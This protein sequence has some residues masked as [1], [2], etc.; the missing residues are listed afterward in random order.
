M[1]KEREYISDAIE[2][3]EDLEIGTNFLVE[4]LEDFLEVNKKAFV[5]ENE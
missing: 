3:K 5:A 4:V 1:K 2:N